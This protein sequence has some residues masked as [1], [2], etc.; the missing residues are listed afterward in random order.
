[1]LGLVLFRLDF[2]NI[3]QE[4]GTYLK[5]DLHSIIIVNFPIVAPVDAINISLQITSD[6]ERTQPVLPPNAKEWHFYNHSRTEH[7]CL[8]NSHLFLELHKYRSFD[9]LKSSLL[10]I[11]EKLIEL[12]PTL[13]F[14]RFGLRYLNSFD[15]KEVNVVKGE[16]KV[17]PPFG[18]KDRLIRQINNIEFLE[19]D[20]FIRFQYGKMN[21]YD[22]PA[23]IKKEDFVIDIDSYA[24][25]IFFYDDI[26]KMLNDAHSHIEKIY[27]DSIEV[28]ND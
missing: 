28:N 25:G 18:V 4:V 17:E 10:P 7:F 2:S 27:Y 26:L 22:Y 8:T 21:T 19:N 15:E 5:K 3:I 13:Q 23:I 14:Q 24:S 12:Y 16:L 11:L 9:E 20:F 1:V 6:V